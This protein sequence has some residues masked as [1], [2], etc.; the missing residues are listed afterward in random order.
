MKLL[1][2]ALRLQSW[3]QR[4]PVLGPSLVMSSDASGSSRWSRV[5]QKART[6]IAAFTCRENFSPE[7]T[8]PP[9]GGLITS[10][11]V[12]PNS[13]EER[14]L[15]PNCSLCTG[16]ARYQCFSCGKGPFCGV[17]VTRVNHNCDGWPTDMEAWLRQNS[18]ARYQK[19]SEQTCPR[20]GDAA[21]N[22]KSWSSSPCCGATLG[23][24][25]CARASVW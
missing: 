3:H 11:W 23:S 21:E 8:G 19:P 15:L 20:E 2:S 4:Q 22:G 16:A 18:N 12:G 7:T 1:S 14:A 13:V 6:A 5:C 10:P 17:C 9:L 25:G 24:T